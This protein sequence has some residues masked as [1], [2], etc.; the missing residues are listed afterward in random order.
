MKTQLDCAAFRFRFGAPSSQHLAIGIRITAESAQ[1]INEVSRLLSL[2]RVSLLSVARRKMEKDTKSKLA[3][4]QSRKTCLPA[5]PFSLL[6]GRLLSVRLARGN[7]MMILSFVAL[8]QLAGQR[9]TSLS[10]DSLDVRGESESER[11][12]LA[13]SRAGLN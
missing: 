4:D 2:N 3:I 5:S 8:Q 9:Q 13:R 11:N 12:W 1:L 10:C 7:L 6:L